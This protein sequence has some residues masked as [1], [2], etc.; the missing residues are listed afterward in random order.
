MASQQSQDGP[1]FYLPAYNPKASISQQDCLDAIRGEVIPKNLGD[2]EDRDGIRIISCII[3]GLR[4]NEA[5][6]ESESMKETCA[7]STNKILAR[8]R[9]ARLIMSNKIPLM[10]N[11]KEKPY[12]IWHPQVATID[13]YRELVQKYPDMRYHV[14]R[15]CAVGGYVD[16]YR[17]L[18]LLPD[19]SIAEEAR[20]NLDV[21]G[22]KEIFDLIMCQPKLYAVLDDYTRSVNWKAPRVAAGLN[23][24]TAVLSSLDVTFEV[25]KEWPKVHFHYFNITE[26]YGVGETS[27]PRTHS[28]PL[29]PEHVPLLYNPLPLH[30]PTTNKDAL[31]VHA[32][33]EGNIDRYARLRRPVMVHSVEGQAVVRGIYHH[34]AF[35]R[36]LVGQ[37]LSVPPHLENDIK[38]AIMARFIMVNDLS[39]IGH[40]QWPMPFMIWWPLIPQEATLRELARRMP[41]MLLPVAITCIIADY[42]WLWEEL[43]PEPHSLLWE[44][45]TQRQTGVSTANQNYYVEDLERR[46]AEKG[47]NLL[48]HVRLRRQDVYECLE[49]IKEP[50]SIF[51]QPY[52][53]I[54]GDVLGDSQLDGVY[55]GGQVYVGNWELC[56]AVSDDV[57]EKART[58]DV[59]H[60]LNINWGWPYSIWDVWASMR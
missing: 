59:D 39:R 52:V 36:W 31:I 8:A 51:L 44:Q 6:A 37:P 7:K 1:G 25:W 42:R 56:I 58:E 19:I 53:S 17:E 43:T 4:Y 34:T 13:T 49:R 16:L 24:D 38:E 47:I 30:L 28:R 22:S 5:F 48:D 46:A 32:A 41:G 21:V 18:D 9:N 57:R 2:I 55:P 3:H 60:C 11:H 15:A 20:D 27:S 33:Y 45:A 23:G 10:T 12:C 35:A 50:T 29:A 40:V 54:D 14:G 26:D